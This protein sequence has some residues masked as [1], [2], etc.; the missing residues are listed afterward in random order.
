MHLHKILFNILD[1]AYL[2]IT[3]SKSHS[4]YETPALFQQEAD[5]RAEADRIEAERIILEQE[6]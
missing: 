1:D 5:T 4:R 2:A 6:L 3:A